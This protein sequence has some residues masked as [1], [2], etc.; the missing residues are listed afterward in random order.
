MGG[1][2]YTSAKLKFLLKL[3]KNII[4]TEKND[5]EGMSS[6]NWGGGVFTFLR[7]GVNKYHCIVL[8]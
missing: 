6:L 8:Y 4:K 3:I 1:G 7:G 2:V 5:L